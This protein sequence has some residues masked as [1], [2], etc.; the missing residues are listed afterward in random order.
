MRLLFLFLVFVVLTSEECADKTSGG[1]PKCI[2]AK[3]D[4]IKSV[5]K[6]NPPAEVNEYSYQG[7]RV[8]L[9]SSDCCDF[10]NPLFDSNCN[11]ICS[12]SGGITGKGDM[13]CTEFSKD[14]KFVKLVWKDNR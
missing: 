4:S 14:A 12:P 10:F 1:I 7:K 9:F 3:I 8:F 11:Y 13:Q 2:Q 5:P 6:W